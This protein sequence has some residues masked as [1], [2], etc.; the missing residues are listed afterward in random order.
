MRLRLLQ[1]GKE[2]GHRCKVSGRMMLS[3]ARGRGFSPRLFSLST[4]DPMKCA[5][6]RRLRRMSA[7][8]A[9]ILAWAR[10][11]I[12]SQRSHMQP[13]NAN[14]AGHPISVDIGHP[15]WFSGIA[16]IGGTVVLGRYSCP[17]SGG[18]CGASLPPPFPNTLHQFLFPIS[19]GYHV[20]ARAVAGDARGVTLPQLL[21][22]VGT[23][24]SP[25]GTIAMPHPVVG[26]Q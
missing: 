5:R 4:R 17:A 9:A 15:T 13:S 8:A 6:L 3:Q 26:D 2:N 14:K 22:G 24:C 23:P 19:D 7:T 20:F 12:S 25:D 1:V 11:R 10:R 16:G 21:D 18:D